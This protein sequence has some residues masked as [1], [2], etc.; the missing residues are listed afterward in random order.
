MH[1]GS[2]PGEASIKSLIRVAAFDWPLWLSFS[3]YP[4]R[5][6]TGVMS[7]NFSQL[8]DTMV[9]GQLRTRDVTHVPVLNA[10]RSIPR[11][12]FVPDS[13]RSLAYLDEDL[14]VAPRSAE[15]PARYLVEPAV[16]ARLLQL[17][18]IKS[19][20]LVL[21]VG[22]ATGYSTAILAHIASFVVGLESDADLAQKASTTLSELDCGNATIVNGPLTAGYAGHAPYD[23]IIL[24]GSVDY[25]PDALLQQ[26]S[27]GGRLVAVIGTGNSARAHIYVKTDGV[28]SQRADFNAAIHPLPGFQLETGFVF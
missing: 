24:Q 17:A 20:D 25:V 21:D 15:S 3:A 27:D 5:S 4:R 9:E 10:F 28:V 11:E 8:R 7:S 16:F 2:I 13:R 6:G 26:L 23:L 14:E 12:Y 19:T 22:C 18:G 1:P